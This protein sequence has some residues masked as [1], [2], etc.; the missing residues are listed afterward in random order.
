MLAI[1]PQSGEPLDGQAL[2]SLQAYVRQGALA[3]E[4]ARLATAVNAAEL[5]AKTEEMRSSLLSAVSH[6]LRTPLAA[7]TGAATTLRADERTLNPIQRAD[8]VEAICEESERLER[9]VVNLLD[10]TRLESG[11]LRV[12]REWVPLE[13]LVGSAL[14]RLE[15][16]LGARE[17]SVQIP[18]GLPLLHVDALLFEQALLNL[19][20]NA[21]KYT[22]ADSP[23]EIHAAQVPAGVEV[24]VVDHGP[25]LPDEL[26]GRVFEKFVRGSHVGVSGAGL[27]LAI[28]K[29]IL[30][31]HGGTIA[32]LPTPNGGATFQLTLPPTRGPAATSE[33]G[34]T[35]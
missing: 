4:R 29:G 26:A 19:L 30:D 21:V 5:R 18:A 35:Q 1:V 23:I 34:T 14:N 13:E 9:L 33:E 16:R 27:G 20:E 10:M 28:C 22:P 11:Q 8:L 17:V 7:I 15:L 25:G 24:A 31:A 12:K 3:L 2:A 32:I 6:D